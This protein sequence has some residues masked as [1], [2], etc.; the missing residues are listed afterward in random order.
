MWFNQGRHG[1]PHVNVANCS[2]LKEQFKP[3]FIPVANTWEEQT[4][5]W[6]NI[7]RDGN[8]TLDEFSY[9]VT[10]LGKALGLNEQ[11]ILDT[12]KLGIPSNV[13]VNLVHI[14]G[15]QTTLNMTKRLMAVPK[16]T[17]P[18]TGVISKA[19]HT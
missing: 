4:L 12:F 8:E 14:D 2:A 18:G 9:K 16:D 10:Q 6:R 7:K 19:L 11:H 3:Q 1:R 5:C 17:S 15:M 13:Y